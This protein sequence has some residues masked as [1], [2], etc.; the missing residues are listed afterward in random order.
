M[1]VTNITRDQPPRHGHYEIVYNCIKNSIPHN[2]QLIINGDDPL[3]TKLALEY[4]GPKTYF[5]MSKHKESFNYPITN[6]LDFI[7]CPK[8]HTKLKYNYVSFS[9]VAINNILIFPKSF[10]YFYLCFYCVLYGS[11]QLLNAFGLSVTNRKPKVALLVIAQ[12]LAIL[13][14]VEF[15]INFQETQKFYLMEAW[16]FPLLI[17]GIA[18]FVY[19]SF[20]YFLLTY[21]HQKKVLMSKINVLNKDIEN[22]NSKK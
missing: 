3:T 21:D 6:A 19:M 12:L 17:I 11:G 14:V 9:N 20:T 15:G 2:C 1:V 8:C 10:T 22:S 13:F 18:A 4:N 5:G 16:T 7:Y